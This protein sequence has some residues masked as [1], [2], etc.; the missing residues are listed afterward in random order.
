VIRDLAGMMSDHLSLSVDVTNARS[1]SEPT[2]PFQPSIEIISP[3]T[4]RKG[5]LKYMF[6]LASL[7]ARKYHFAIGFWTQDNILLALA[8][9]KSGTRVILCEHVTHN[10]A[11]WPIRLLRRL[12]YRLAWRVTV[13]NEADFA[14]YR[15]FLRTVSLVPN[16]VDGAQNAERTT[17]QNMILGVG[18]LVPLKGF[19]D[20]ILAFADSDLPSNAWRLVIIGEGPEEEKLRRLSE[21]FAPGHVD[22]VA[23][24]KNIHDWYSRA[25][26][27]AITSNVEAFSLVL[28]EGIQAGL[29]PVA[30]ATPGPSFILKNFPDH[31]VAVGDRKGLTDRLSRLANATDLTSAN[32]RMRHDLNARMSPERVA[33]LWRDVLEGNC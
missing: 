29:V 26:I 31:L 28:A 19:D 11:P 21:A 1:S 18:H 25:K 7:R 3:A 20:L 5:L 33:A 16:P 14:Y 15:G 4:P 32:E 22:F 13:L 27:I 8:M 23:P 24:T 30:Y 12:V 17:R 10:F 6:F 2:Y 9:A